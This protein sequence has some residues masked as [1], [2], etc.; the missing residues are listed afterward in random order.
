MKIAI[1]FLLLFCSQSFAGNYN[2]LST[3]VRLQFSDDIKTVGEAA[4]YLVEIIDYKVVTTRDLRTAPKSSLEIYNSKL[5]VYA[6]TRKVLRLEDALLRLI[7]DE[8]K[9]IVDHPHQLISFEKI[10]E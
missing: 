6:K 5:K 10:E 8:N 3:P 4:S 9:L 7:G 1:S 2:A